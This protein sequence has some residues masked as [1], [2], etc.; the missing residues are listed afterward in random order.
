SLISS[1]KKAGNN[2]KNAD[3]ALTSYLCFRV[4]LKSSLRQQMPFKSTQGICSHKVLTQ[5]NTSR[6]K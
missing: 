2:F 3:N 1:L 4:S 6:M 5:C